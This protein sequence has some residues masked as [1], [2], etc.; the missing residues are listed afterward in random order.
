M[1]PKG[2]GKSFGQPVAEAPVVVDASGASQIRRSRPSFHEWKLF[3]VS[4]RFLPGRLNSVGPSSID[5]FFDA[6]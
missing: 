4:L 3:M 6:V 5:T 1:G 2:R